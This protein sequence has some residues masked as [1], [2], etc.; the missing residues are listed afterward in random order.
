MK[1]S[2]RSRHATPSLP[3][4]M[5]GRRDFVVTRPGQA[6]RSSTGLYDSTQS[7][8]LP[9]LGPISIGETCSRPNLKPY[10]NLTRLFICL[11]RRLSLSL[12]RASNNGLEFRFNQSPLLPV[13]LHFCCLLLYVFRMFRSR[14]SHGIASVFRCGSV[15]IS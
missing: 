5:L 7:L 8:Q 13:F 4:A 1:R 12:S 14:A 11:M 3:N 9:R 10:Q 2:S 6:W 15:W